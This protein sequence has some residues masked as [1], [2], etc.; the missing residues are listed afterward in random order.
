MLI[1]G[2]DLSYVPGEGP[3]AKEDAILSIDSGVVLRCR[4][5]VRN[6]D[7]F[8]FFF[9]FF[10]SRPRSPSAAIV[11]RYGGAVFCPCGHSAKSHRLTNRPWGMLCWTRSGLLIS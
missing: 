7:T 1:F 11:L 9:F 10:F 3:S 5:I 4:G 8:F 2:Y 6:L